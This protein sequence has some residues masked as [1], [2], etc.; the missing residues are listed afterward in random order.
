MCDIP[1]TGVLASAFTVPAIETRL[2]RD[3]GLGGAIVVA[4]Q[5]VIGREKYDLCGLPPKRWR[6]STVV[7]P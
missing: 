3:P 5:T 6:H 4:E 7:R 1:T 2:K